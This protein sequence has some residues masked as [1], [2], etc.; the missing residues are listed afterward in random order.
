MFSN[1]Q[2]Y[3]KLLTNRHPEYADVCLNVPL[4][5]KLASREELRLISKSNTTSAVYQYKKA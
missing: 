4:S 2:S 3:N 1:N 5:A